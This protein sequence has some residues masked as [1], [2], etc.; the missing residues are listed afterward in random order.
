[1]KICVNPRAIALEWWLV[2]LIPIVTIVMGAA[3]LHVASTFGFTALG[4]PV[5]TAVHG[6]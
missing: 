3:M 5:Q 4:E 6:G 1:M 2:I